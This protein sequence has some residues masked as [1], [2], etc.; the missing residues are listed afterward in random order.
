M[1][2]CYLKRIR[3]V[4]CSLLAAE[5]LPLSDIVDS[6]VYLTVVLSELLFND[7]NCIPV[8]VITD[9]KSL[10]NALHSKKNVPEKWLQT[11]MAGFDLFIVRLNQDLFNPIQR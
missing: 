5:T 6:G 9:S 10:Y 7:R 8:E 2:S 1:L 3:R 4:I 11:Y